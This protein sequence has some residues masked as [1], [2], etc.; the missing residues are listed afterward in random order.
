MAINAESWL[1]VSVVPGERTAENASSVVE[2]FKRRTAGRLMD[3]ISTD[4]H[5]AYET[6]ILE[7]YGETITPFRT[8]RRIRPK[9][10]YNI[11]PKGLMYAVVENTR[12]KGSV[13][14]FA[15][16]MIFGAMAAVVVALGM[17]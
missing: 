17:S 1:V 11:A 14:S 4:G 16:R 2:D 13:V 9:A 7:A 6:A 10:P 12:Q 15:T 8:G 3:L 5:P